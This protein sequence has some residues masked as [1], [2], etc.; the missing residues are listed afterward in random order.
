VRAGLWKAWLIPMLR[1]E[2]QP[3]MPKVPP[4]KHMRD[5]VEVPY[6]PE[7][8]EERTQNYNNKKEIWNKTMQ[9]Q[10]RTIQKNT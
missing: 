2:Y 9:V 10:T 7:E 8:M 4:E 5:R 6:T 3:S 1:G